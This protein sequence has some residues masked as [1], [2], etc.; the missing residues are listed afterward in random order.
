MAS[1]AAALAAVGLA[2]MFQGVAAYHLIGHPVPYFSS[3]CVGVQLAQLPSA[4]SCF[5]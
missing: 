3:K 4:L 5:P 2:G 1:Q